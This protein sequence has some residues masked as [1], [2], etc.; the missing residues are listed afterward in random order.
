MRSPLILTI[1][2][3]FSFPAS[4][5]VFIGKPIAIDGDTIAVGDTHI[6][7]FGIDAVEGAQTCSR[8][9]EQWACGQ[10]AK[11]R[12]ASILTEGRLS[13][14]PRGTDHLG[15]SIA[16]CSAG[17]HDLGLAMVEAGFAIALPDAPVGYGQIEAR[18]RTAKVGI[19]GTEFI[20]PKDYRASHPREVRRAVPPARPTVF[21]AARRPAPARPRRVIRNCNDAWLAGIAPIYRGDPGYRSAWDGD[22]DG[23]ACEPIY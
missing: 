8:G 7:L 13:C 18:Q 19:W 2:A 16:T 9:T 17:G 21:R 5:Q 12:L 1:A 10:D 20:P 3:L 14:S 11:A 23:I 4:G 6:R 22:H 15:F